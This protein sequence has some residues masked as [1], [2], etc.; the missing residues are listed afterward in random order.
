[1]PTPSPVEDLRQQRQPLTAWLGILLLFLLFGL[2]VL[3]VVGASPRGSTY[4]QKRAAARAE[5]LKA[6]AEEQTKALAGYGWVDKEKGTVR[7][8]VDRAM[9]LAL[10]ELKQKAPAPAYP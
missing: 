1:M 4:E 6:A 2:L 10:A 7:I 8:P 5:K 3:T 9:E